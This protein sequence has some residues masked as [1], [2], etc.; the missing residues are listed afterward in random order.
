MKHI[1]LLTDFSDT[2]KNAIDYALK[3]FEKDLCQF[4]VL[5]VHKMGSYTVDN[6][7]LTAATENIYNSIIQEQKDALNTLI[8]DIET[9]ND[10]SKHRFEALVDYDDFIDAIN[11]IISIKNI[12]LVVI[13]SNGKTGAQEVI[14]GSNTLNVIRRVNCTT[15]VI[16]ENYAFNENKDA[17]L[18]LDCTDSL[19]GDALIELHK[20]IKDYNYKLHVLRITAEGDQ[21][22]YEFYDQSNLTAMAH[23]Y[24]VVHDVP[25]HHATNS[26]VQIKNIGL[27]AI[28]THKEKFFH[29]FIKG[30]TTTKLNNS[31]HVP[32][33][34][35]HND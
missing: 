14:F 18:P 26:F 13:G 33:L 30:S 5:H 34:V 6:L 21:C 1:L 8:S 17:L 3:F 15:M 28:I 23:Q 20:F 31:L 25:V 16:P 11:Q 4:Y 7:M 10:N 2:S 19:H 12:D 22:E 27:T 32:L 35:L 24:Y 29:R 9:T